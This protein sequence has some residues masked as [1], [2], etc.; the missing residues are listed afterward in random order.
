MAEGTDPVQFT[1]DSARR[2]GTA[3]R[4]VESV[5][6]GGG[7]PRRG[8]LNPVPAE[9]FLAKITGNAALAATDFRWKYAW[10]EVLMT[11]DLV[12]TRVGGRTGTTTTD[13]ATNTAEMYHTSTY[14]W[15]VDITGTDYDATTSFAPRPIGGGGA[16]DTHRYD[17][18]V[19]LTQVIDTAGNKKY[20]FTLM[21]SHDG[22]C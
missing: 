9:K 16:A 18:V 5:P 12:T 1:L 2:I 10:T 15:G 20:W 14:A 7:L 17:V 13:Y 4:R 19:E 6:D 3:V 11:A 21:G 22:A 8:I